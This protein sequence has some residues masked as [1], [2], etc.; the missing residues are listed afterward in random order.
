M[1]AKNSKFV[2]GCI[3]FMLPIPDRLVFHRIL[4]FF[5]LALIYCRGRFTRKKIII[6]CTRNRS[7]QLFAVNSLSWAKWAHHF[8][9]G[10]FGRMKAAFLITIFV[11]ALHR[12]LLSLIVMLIYSP[13]LIIKNGQKSTFTIKYFNSRNTQIRTLFRSQSFWFRLIA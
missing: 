5:G 3:R 2:N 13:I 8:L 4:C 10:F 11:F 6:N 12:T 9:G 1:L 7:E